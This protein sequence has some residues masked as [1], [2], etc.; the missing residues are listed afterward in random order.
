MDLLIWSYF[1][2]NLV[3]TGNSVGDKASVASQSMS[4]FLIV[5]CEKMFFLPFYV[6]IHFYY[7]KFAVHAVNMYIHA[8]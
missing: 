5:G 2:K 8:C 6:K 1:G 4:C 3:I 7:D